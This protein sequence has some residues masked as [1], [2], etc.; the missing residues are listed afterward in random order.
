MYLILYNK[1]LFNEK[2]VLGRRS[3][4]MG[5]KLKLYFKEKAI[6]MIPRFGLIL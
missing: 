3:P 1:S 4:G 6:I 5:R 2:R